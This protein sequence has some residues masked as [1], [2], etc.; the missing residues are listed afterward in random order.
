MN[1]K[2]LTVLGLYATLSLAIYAAESALP[3]LAPIPGFKLG[4]ANIITIIL[5]HRYS[6]R[7]AAL[8]LTVRILLSAMLFGQ[9]LSLLYSLAGGICSLSV[10]YPVS[11]LLQKKLPPLTGAMGGLAHN[12]GQL[13]A[14]FL[15]TATPGVLAYL[16]LLLPAGILTGLFTGLCAWL[17]DKYLPRQ[18]I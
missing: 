3:P 14:A 9:V 5:L 10:M 16:P 18:A 13:L 2:K 8:V 4:L 1:T 11:R 17:A 15:I 6:F 7:D 12:A